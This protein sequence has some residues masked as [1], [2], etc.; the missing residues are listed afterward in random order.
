MLR[1]L[2]AAARAFQSDEF[3]RL[4]IRNGEFLLRE[5]VRDGRVMRTHKNGESRIGGFLEDHAA[6]ALG[7]V[8]LYELTF[9]S[10]WVERANVIAGAMIEWFWDDQLNTFFDTA[11]DA[12]ALITR[13]REVTDNAIPSGT[14]LA[15]DLLLTLS[16]LRHDADMRRMATFVIESLAAPL[17]EHPTSFGHLL[18]A[19]DMAINGAVEV[20][21]AG[22]GTIGGFG[23]WS[24]K[25]P[26]TTFPRWCSPAAMAKAG[27][28]F[29]MAEC[30]GRASQRRTSAGR[31]PVTNRRQIQPCW[32][33]SSMRRA[34]FELIFTQ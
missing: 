2:A 7:F 33:A 24:M 1:G 5:M 28:R 17:A 22:I 18:G 4:A 12:E 8:A 32:R 19:A 13:P 14:S 34:E 9:D 3:T 23:Y 31:T 20:A 26:L 16:E 10:A 6:V 25:S 29:W 27:S 11:K 15:I 21:I 30:H